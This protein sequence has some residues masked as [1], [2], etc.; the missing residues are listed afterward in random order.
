MLTFWKIPGAHILG[1]GGTSGTSV[2]YEKKK[3]RHWAE[4]KRNIA[5]SVIEKPRE[6]KVRN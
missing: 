5:Y 1:M 6:T 3:R 4:L 2:S